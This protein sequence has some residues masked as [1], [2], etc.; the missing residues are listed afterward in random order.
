MSKPMPTLC[1]NA[2]PLPERYRSFINKDGDLQA[3]DAYGL[4]AQ[5]VLSQV[6]IADKDYYPEME[7][8]RFDV[9]E[10]SWTEGCKVCGDVECDSIYG[11][12]TS[13]ETLIQYEQGDF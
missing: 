9:E 2:G 13:C 10:D 3:G 7:W 8:D 1:A 4:E 11:L 12:C 5:W 6:T